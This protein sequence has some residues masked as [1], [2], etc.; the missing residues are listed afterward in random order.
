MHQ[1][2]FRYALSFILLLLS[3]TTLAGKKTRILFLLDA[4]SSMTYP[5][6]PGYSRYEVATNILLNIVDSVYAI[7][8]EIEFAVRAYGT[9]HPAQEK[10]CSDT[11]LEVPFNFQNVNQ[12]KTRLQYLKPIGFSPIAYSLEQA[13]KNELGQPNEY[14]YSIIFIT[15]GGESCN[16]DIC[17]TFN[18]FLKNKI[19]I[20]P[21]VIGLDKN[22]KLKSY[23]DCMGNYI[24]VS[25]SSD[26]PKAVALIVNA[27]QK[28]IDKPKVLNLNTTLSKVEPI[29]DTTPKV[30][31]LP[32]LKKDE[33]VVLDFST[34]P[35]KTNKVKLTTDR[36][37]PMLSNHK[38]TLRFTLD[39]VEI[40]KPILVKPNSERLQPT[41]FTRSEEFKP[42]VTA[43]TKP[44]KNKKATLRFEYDEPVERDKLIFSSL[45]FEPYEVKLPTLKRINGKALAIKNKKVKL[46]FDYDEPVKRDSFKIKEMLAFNF[47][48]VKKK[49]I[50]F[51][52]KNFKNNSKNKAVV[53]ID[54]EVPVIRNLSVISELEPRYYIQLKQ[55]AKNN[56]L[57][58]AK[59]INNKEKA[60]V[61]FD[62]E[63]LKKENM[64]N[65]KFRDYPKR[66]GY[67][68]ALPSRTYPMLKSKAVIHFTLESAKPVVKKDSSSKPK[69]N[70][71]DPMQYEVKTEA[72]AETKI[73]IFL[74]GEDGKEYPKAQPTI[75]I[76]NP[77][78]KDTLYRFIRTMED[79]KPKIE[80]IN[81]GNYDVIIKEYNV[82]SSFDVKIE[83]NKINK[84]TLKLRKGTLNFA[85]S[86]E[87]YKPVKYN[88][89]VIKR[90]ADKRNVLQKCTDVLKYDPGQ[91]YIEINT[92]PAYKT[93]IF[94]DFF[95][96]NYVFL[97]EPGTIQFTNS[98]PLGKIALQ[99][100]L[101]DGFATFHEINITGKI[102]EQTLELLP[103]IYKAIIPVDPKVPLAGSKIVDFRVE[104]G[105]NKQLELR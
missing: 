34:F 8:N 18:H 41:W 17:A 63:V 48:Q 44:V 32:T 20:Q 10:N 101:G 80:S 52:A 1:T 98:S 83:P 3:L 90:F 42:K 86:N 16:G 100:V 95:A 51:V 4:S 46:R 102:N 23:Y 40:T 6:N 38:A 70:A 55:S 78:T 37:M 62:Y 105:K 69:N 33:M 43:K 84:I 64:L 68:M 47:L 73:Q 93:V 24:E 50:N 65:L 58:K 35:F 39:E 19:S 57:G 27:N 71:T 28:I 99:C 7:N 13:S 67:A 85:Y 30:I 77:T 22:D 87:L 25:E 104:S 97:K 29:K 96:E 45:R 74:V 66:T 11:K 5:W 72:S 76:L 21:Y 53:R 2:K 31:P 79:G 91:Y 36:S 14:D 81:P 49:E 88:A 61:R 15:D 9:Q 82:A 26:I 54:Y 60:L 59:K 12:I 92:L 75:Q 94:I 89:V 103:G 56:L